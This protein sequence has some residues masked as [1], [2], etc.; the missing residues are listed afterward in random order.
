[1]LL[2]SCTKYL[3]KENSDTVKVFSELII[4]LRTK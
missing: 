3:N 4:A 1:M 2:A